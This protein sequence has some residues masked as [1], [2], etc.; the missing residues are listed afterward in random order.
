MAALSAASKLL[1]AS[2]LSPPLKA[3][4]LST[5]TGRGARGF[6]Q[7]KEGLLG[8]RKMSLK[9]M[10]LSTIN[11]GEKPD[12]VDSF[13]DR[14]GD[15]EGTKAHTSLEG[16]AATGAF[17]IKDAKGLVRLPKEEDRAF[18][19]RV[20]LKHQEEI[21]GRVG[22]KWEGLPEGVKMAV[23][24]LKFNMGSIGSGLTKK[25]KAGA[26]PRDVMLETLDTVRSTLQSDKGVFKKGDSILVPGLARRR[27]SNWN[28]AFPDEQVSKVEF[29]RDGEHTTV[30]YVGDGGVVFSYKSKAP[31]S[32]DFKTESGDTTIDVLR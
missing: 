16:G 4:G 21:K 18:A 29:K 3:A 10:L 12:V 7:M 1:K 25:V 31:V 30:S 5:R 8:S 24:D 22:D 11:K 2:L 6:K 9:Q 13:M 19:K 26:D 20:V 28:Q 14:I 27:A 23:L 17:G 15:F 32:S